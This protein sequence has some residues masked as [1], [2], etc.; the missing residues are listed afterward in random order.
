[1]PLNEQLA[2]QLKGYAELI[3]VL[4]KKVEKNRNAEAEII[5]IA[6]QRRY[7]PIDYMRY[8]EF[9]AALRS[10]RLERGSRVLDASGPQW[11]T[12]ALALQHTDI[13]F[14]YINVSIPVEE[15]LALQKLSAMADTTPRLVNAAL[16]LSK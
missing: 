15:I 16:H 5:R 2:S 7:R 4:V 12:F 3:R 6:R 8:A 11:L 10:L 9:G 13:E 1:M 14:Y